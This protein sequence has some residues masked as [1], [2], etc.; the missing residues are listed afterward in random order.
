MGHSPFE[1]TMGPQSLSSR[2]YQ[3]TRSKIFNSCLLIRQ[4]LQQPH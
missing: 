3:I 4:E 2:T 1:L